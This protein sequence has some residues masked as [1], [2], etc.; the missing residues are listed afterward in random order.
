MFK[1]SD[2]QRVIRSNNSASIFSA[3]RKRWKATKSG[4]SLRSA[5]N[6]YLDHLRASG[7][8]SNTIYC[9]S[10]D[11]IRLLNEFSDM[12]LKSINQEVL[13]EHII[14]IS[15]ER[16]KRSVSNT[17]QRSISTINRIKIVYRSFFKWCLAK[18]LMKNDLSSEL[19]LSKHPS[20]LTLPI[21]PEEI[22][23]LLKVISESA[24]PLAQRDRALFSV[25]AFSGIRRSEAL[26]LRVSDYDPQSRTISVKSSK[27]YTRKL[28][29]IP[30]I[31]F[32]VM[33]QYVRVSLKNAEPS[34]PLFLGQGKNR[35]L[36]SRQASN[37]FEKWK[38]LAGIR[39]TLTI[40]S[41]RSGYASRLYQISKDPLLVSHAL[42]HSSFSTTER[43]I[44]HELL[45]LSGLVETAFSGN[46]TR[47]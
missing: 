27:G 4:I 13:D 47:G 37:R 14:H 34:S 22:T 30:L 28:Q 46:G 11:L 18:G 38:K 8:S 10:H 29:P 17:L 2:C 19:R 36:S 41:F 21:L 31:L 20:S 25:Y 12:N 1:Q 5:I 45:D 24:D 35:S 9:Y 16:A 43:Y 15:A 23:R 3:L 33:D 39:D 32:D 26:T 42:G 6:T 7:L 44:K 40:H